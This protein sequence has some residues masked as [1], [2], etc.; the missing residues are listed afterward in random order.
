MKDAKKPPHGELRGPNINGGDEMLSL[1]FFWF[2]IFYKMQSSKSTLSASSL[3]QSDLVK[4]S[5][6]K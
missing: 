5:A 2:R 3:P 1:A 6:T 4:I